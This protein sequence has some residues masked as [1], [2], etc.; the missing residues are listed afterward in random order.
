MDHA[1][2]HTQDLIVFHG[3][4]NDDLIDGSPVQETPHIEWPGIKQTHIK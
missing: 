4:E 3:F 1:L 2:V